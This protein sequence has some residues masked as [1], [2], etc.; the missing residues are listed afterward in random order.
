MTKYKI[1]I[2]ELM[3]NDSGREIRV[4]TVQA[5]TNGT[6]TL[7]SVKLIDTTVYYYS[8][9]STRDAP[10]TAD[11]FGYTIED[12][13]GQKAHAN[14][15]VIFPADYADPDPDE[16]G[17]GDDGDDGDVPPSICGFDIKYNGAFSRET[18]LTTRLKATGW[19][20]Q[21]GNIAI[22]STIKYHRG[23]ADDFIDTGWKLLQ[24]N[25]IP[26]A[27]ES[28]LYYRVLSQADCNLINGQGMLLCTD[29][30][31]GSPASRQIAGFVFVVDTHLSWEESYVF[32][33]PQ[34]AADGNWAS[35]QGD[36]GPGG[37]GYASYKVYG[38]AVDF[39]FFHACDFFLDNGTRPPNPNQRPDI[40]PSIGPEVDNYWGISTYHV[41]K[42]ENGQS[43]PD[44]P[45]PGYDVTNTTDSFYNRVRLKFK[46]CV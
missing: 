24:F 20:A 14:V 9:P 25:G 17:D 21:P 4:L 36:I 22:A 7:G 1:P 18:A 45:V 19:R 15:R 41:Q 31:Y 3:T 16:P 27:Y 13:Y 37:F 8:P 28:G 10:I 12:T 2:N 29:S 46:P 38:P 34:Y 32:S 23:G 44:L 5:P 43:G 40:V 11:N 30:D 42:Y 35:T 26:Y 33:E 39:H 6:T